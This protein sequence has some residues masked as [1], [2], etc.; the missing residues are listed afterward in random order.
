MLAATGREG[1]A[2][3]DLIGPGNR[4][5]G[6]ASEGPLFA[7]ALLAVVAAGFVLAGLG[8]GDRLRYTPELALIPVAAAALMLAHYF[9]YDAYY[10]LDL[11]RYSD[12]GFV[13]MSAVVGATAIAICA[14]LLLV[15]RTTY[16]GGAILAGFVLPG[17][18]FLT[19][20]SQT[21]H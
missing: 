19:I 2:A 6:G 4:P 5:G 13:P 18:A 12:H 15:T 21:G 20:L 14:A 11:R 10:G 1:A 3:I 16:R 9:G 8:L 17:V 7:T